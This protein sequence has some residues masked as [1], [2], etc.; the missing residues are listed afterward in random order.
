M[1]PDVSNLMCYKK[2][3]SSIRETGIH[4]VNNLLANLPVHIKKGNLEDAIRMID[5]EIGGLLGN[6]HSPMVET[7]RSSERLLFP[8]GLENTFPGRDIIMLLNSDTTMIDIRHGQMQ[9]KIPKALKNP[10]K[11]V[12]QV[13]G[14][15]LAITLFKVRKE[16]LEA[17]VKKEKESQGLSSLRGRREF[18]WMT[19]LI[20]NKAAQKVLE[21]CYWENRPNN[22]S[23]VIHFQNRRF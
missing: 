23:M 21:K 5:R 3:S 12:A 22:S 2:N 13:I 9:Y 19:N 7:F 1:E 20:A 15:D 10:E 6:P 14:I 4:A 17:L 11:G 18:T 8:G 16:V